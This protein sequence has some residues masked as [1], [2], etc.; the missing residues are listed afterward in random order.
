MHSVQRA[1]QSRQNAR[2]FLQSSEFGVS[3]LPHPQASVPPPP[4][5]SGGGG[6]GTLAGGRGG[7]PN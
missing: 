2:L 6:G 5:D 1:T 4:I 7:G 3:P